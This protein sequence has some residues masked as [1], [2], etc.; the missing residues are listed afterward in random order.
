MKRHLIIKPSS[1][2][3][4]IMAIPGVESL[5]R[6][7]GG[8]IW[9]VC[10]QAVAPILER[11]EFIDKIIVFDEEKFF[12]GSPLDRF[13][14]LV[15]VWRSL[16]GRSFD[17]YAILQFNP[18]YQVIGMLSRSSRKIF[19]KRGDRT[20]DLIHGRSQSDEFAR[21]LLGKD[22]PLP[23]R[24]VPLLFSGLT[25]RPSS[26]RMKVGIAP[27]GARNLV[28]DSPLRRWPLQY[29]VDL[30]KLLLEHGY[31]VILVGSA[32]DRWTLPAFEN[33]PVTDRLG[34]HSLVESIELIAQLDV[35]VTHDTGILHMAGLTETPI[36]ALF[37]P[38]AP[39]EFLPNRNHV[40]CFWGGEGLAC[41]PCYDG[42]SLP[43][44]CPDQ[45]CLK[46]TRPDMV[47][48]SVENFVL[49][50]SRRHSAANAS[51]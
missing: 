11:Y 22:G 18:K 12:K 40:T 8:E 35:M 26:S 14:E 27:G 23:E 39:W 19:L 21:I 25:P 43:D 5:K 33:C 36:V 2:G 28:R 51:A 48:Q 44:G 30:A 42:R 1:I 6:H 50:D 38:T 37:G 10:G 7:Q 32:S 45:A 4:V 9:W 24:T 3:D 47:F 17:T 34:S 16:A 41:R 20:R 15:R 49:S 29:Y 31:E 46:S 13:S